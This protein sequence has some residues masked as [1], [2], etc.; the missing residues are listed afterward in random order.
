MRLNLK[1]HITQWDMSH[2][3]RCWMSTWAEVNGNKV[4]DPAKWL[5]FSTTAVCRFLNVGGITF[6][7]HLQISPPKCLVLERCVTHTR[8]KVLNLSKNSHFQSLIFDKIHIFQ[9]SN[10]RE[11]LDKMLGFLQIFFFQN[12]LF[13]QA[14]DNVESSVRKASVFCMVALHQLVGDQLQPHLKCLNGSKLK[15]LNLY[16]KRAE[17]QSMPASP[18]LT[19]P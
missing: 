19:P 13:F 10:S 16:I 14:Y 2:D 5:I 6:N 9:T 15:L 8:A 4:N 17:A 7:R 12:S 18:R 3:H 1:S 11:F